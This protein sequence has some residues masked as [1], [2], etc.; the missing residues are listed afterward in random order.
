PDGA[1]LI[2]AD[3]RASGDRIVEHTLATGQDRE[4]FSEEGVLNPRDLSPDGKVLLYVA[5]RS[6]KYRRIDTPAGAPQQFLDSGSAQAK[7]SPD[8][9]WVV[10]SFG[11]ERARIYVQ[12]FPFGGL[13]TQIT[14]DRGADPVWRGDGKEIV[15]RW[16][17]SLYS[18][19]V[20]IHGSQFKASEPEL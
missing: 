15:Y 10:Y 18:V 5:N 4:L 2:Y 1:R 20:E 7:F 19:R 13:R 11:R 17:S 3:H 12:A 16:N 8:G 14:P 6:L 9:K